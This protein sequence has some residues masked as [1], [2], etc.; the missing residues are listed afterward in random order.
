MG[1]WCRLPDGRLGYPFHGRGGYRKN[2]QGKEELFHE[3]D[4]RLQNGWIVTLQEEDYGKLP[5][6]VEPRPGEWWQIRF[7]ETHERFH[8]WTGPWREDLQKFNWSGML[9]CG[10]LVPVFAPGAMDGPT[11]WQG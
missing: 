9:K 6:G 1:D 3:T 2:S 5:R 10:C 8:P 11:G 4:F 7:C